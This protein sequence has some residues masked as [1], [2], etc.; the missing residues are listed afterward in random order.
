M[1]H[2]PLAV[3]KQ[4]F[5][6][7]AKLVAAVQKLATDDLWLPRVSESKGFGRIANAK[8]VRLHERLTLAKEKFG[9]RGKLIEAILDVEK[10][11]KDA[12]YKARLEGYPLPRLLD[13]WQAASKR[14]KRAAAAAAATPAK[15]ATPAKAKASGAKKA[16]K[17]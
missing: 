2:A 15:P 10:R 12:G 17:V 14:A 3:V 1:A 5:G 4:R 11:P 7:K 6:D 13:L 8:L 9:T 16:A